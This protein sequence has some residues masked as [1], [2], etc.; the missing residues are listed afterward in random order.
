MRA[1][2]LPKVGTHL[3]REKSQ[4]GSP[5]LHNYRSTSNR[6]ELPVRNKKIIRTGCRSYIVATNRVTTK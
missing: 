4:A 6:V 5:S 2:A 3:P 1:S